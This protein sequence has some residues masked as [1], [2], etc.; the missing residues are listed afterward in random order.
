M[1]NPVVLFDGVCNLCSA[2]VQWI[3]Q[4]DATGVFH[5]ASLQSDFGQKIQEKYGMDAAKID[6]VL[7]VAD[8][9]I[10]SKSDAA[11]QIARRLGGFWKIGYGFIIFP[12]FLRDLVYDFV[13]RNRYRW[14]GKKEECWLPNP[15]FKD[16]FLD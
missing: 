3:L 8:G 2:A 9:K 1:T 11:L 6:S 4:R 7:L 16:K 12:K 13:A 15:K 14:F 5:F 10:Y